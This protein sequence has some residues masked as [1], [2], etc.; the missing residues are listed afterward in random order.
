MKHNGHTARLLSL[1]ANPFLLALAA[2]A[3]IIALLPMKFPKF[4]A[5]MTSQLRLQASQTTIIYDDLDGNGYGDMITAGEN[6]IG[7]SYLV[8]NFLPGQKAAQWNVKGGYI[9][10]TDGYIITGDYDENG[11]REIYLFTM[12][13]DSIFLH[14]IS[15]IAGTRSVPS[16]RFIARVGSK[17]GKTDASIIPGSMDDLDGDGF[18][19]L[20][21][22]VNTG[23][24]IYPRTVFAYNIHTG[25][26]ISSPKS[27]YQI[28]EIIQADITGDGKNEIIPVGYAADNIHD[29]NYPYHDGSNWLMALDCEL[30]FVFPPVEFPGPSGSFYPLIVPDNSMSPI[31]GAIA[32]IPDTDGYKAK[33]CIVDLKGRIVKERNIPLPDHGS[34]IDARTF[35]EKSFTYIGMLNN[36]GNLVVYDTSLEP[37]SS[38][39]L[40]LI[41]NPLKI[42]MDLDGDSNEEFLAPIYIKNQMIIFQSGFTHPAVVDLPLQGGPKTS[43]SLKLNGDD[44]PEL[45]VNSGDILT[46]ITYGISPLYY[47]KWGIY[48]GIYLAVLLFTLLVQRAQRY[49]IQRRYETEK[50]IAELQLKIVRNQLDP[51]FAFN[52]I[53]SALNAINN[54]KDEEAGIYLQ[55]FASMYRS[56]VLSSDKISRTLREEIEFTGNYLKMEQFR[57]NQRFRYRIIKAP[58]VNLEWEVPKMIIQS[59]TENAVKHGLLNKKDSIGMLEINIMVSEGNLVIVIEDNGIGR[60][61]S[62]QESSDSTGKGME[63][64]NSLYELYHRITNIKIASAL[65]DLF[66][67]DG[68]ACGTKVKITV[69]R[70]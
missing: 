40:G 45:A 10:Y 64:M 9:F 68:H 54:H 17:E 58:D 19:E 66:D 27:G 46:T 35:N 5:E 33:F 50:K 63:I 67:N 11:I 24:S 49:R 42:I 18:R 15:Q 60:Q 13:S 55:H 25:T 52:A 4:R 39:K 8:V 21:F 2:S 48:S 20:I 53:N 51:H 56:L 3:I 14:C 37:V 30:R 26:L 70:P 43:F 57:F 1:M 69:Q 41:C 62:A 28:Q 23:F 12:V 34:I 38:H 59:Y 44:A 61:Q 7:N 6:F 22:A 31:L 47:G 65:D 36:D 29:T 16:S 32:Y